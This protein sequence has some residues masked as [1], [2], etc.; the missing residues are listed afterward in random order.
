[1]AIVCNLNVYFYPSLAE[2]EAYEQ[3]AEAI[4]VMAPVTIKSGFNADVVA[5]AKPAVD[6]STMVLD[7]QGWVLYNEISRK[8]AA[9][10]MMVS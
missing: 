4:M 9:C 3:L 5:E 10:L 7:D 1:M 6:H 8:K 2:V